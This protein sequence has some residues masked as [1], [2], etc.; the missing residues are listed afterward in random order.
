MK[1]I[2]T[3]HWALLGVIVLRSATAMA[4]PAPPWIP[5]PA[6]S[7]W[8][9]FGGEN[10]VMAARG[11]EFL[12]SGEG[13]LEPASID[14]T[15]CARS[16]HPQASGQPG[17]FYLRAGR[18]DEMGQWLGPDHEVLLTLR[19]YAQPHAT[20]Y[21]VY[22]SADYTFV[23]RG[24]EP[25]AWNLACK[26]DLTARKEFQSLQVRLPLMRFTRR[27]NGGDIRIEGRGF[28]LAGAAL[29]RVPKAAEAA[30]EPLRVAE[31]SRLKLQMDRTGLRRLTEKPRG[32]VYCDATAKHFPL[33]ELRMKKEG[34]APV[35][36]VMP[37]EKDFQDFRAETV[38]ADTVRMRMRWELPNHVGIEAEAMLLPSGQIEW[39]VAIDN[40][41]ALEVAEI[42]FPVLPGFAVG[43]KASDC[44]VFVPT[45]WGRATD[46][47]KP[48]GPFNG[49]RW[50]GHWNAQGGFYL[51]IEDPAFHD[52]VF[53][54]E[55]DTGGRWNLGIRQ[56]GRVEPGRQWRSEVIRAAVTS[57]DWHE[58]GDIYRAFTAKTLAPC[59]YP[60]HVKWLL[61]AWDTSNAND[62]PQQ[63][64]ALLTDGMEKREPFGVYFFATNRQMIEG[65]TSYS[66]VGFPAYP[67]PAWGSEREFRQQLRALKDRGGM[68]VPYLNYQN[69]W[70]FYQEQVRGRQRV[71]YYPKSRLPSDYLKYDD[72]WIDEAASHAY[73]GRPTG[74]MAAGSPAWAD[75]VAQVCRR[76][77]D[78]GMDGMY[79]DQTCILTPSGRT[80]PPKYPGYG[81]NL[82]AR[83]DL[84][85]RIRDEVRRQNPYFTLSGELIIDVMC[86]ALDLPMTSSVFPNLD[87]Y[88]YCN[89][90]HIMIHGGWNGGYQFM[91]GAEQVRSTWQ[92]GVRFEQMVPRTF[93]GAGMY[94]GV[95]PKL[96]GREWDD[97]DRQVLELRRAVKSI[98]Y[99]AEYRDG[100]GL[101]VHDAA[102]KSLE[103]ERSIPFGG[104]PPQRGIFGRW[105]RF[106]KDGES[107]AAINI[108]N[109]VSPPEMALK[110]ATQDSVK[111][112][113]LP[114]PPQEGATM[115]FSTSQT[116][117]V[118][119][120]VAWTLEGKCFAIN[121]RQEGSRY[122]FPVPA[123]EMSSVVLSCGKL[124]PVVAWNLD[125]V[126]A[127]GTCRMLKLKITNVN[128]E[129][130]TGRTR[131]L[132]PKGWPA[133]E[134][135]AFGPLK[136]G[137]TADVE[138]PVVVP[139]GAENGRCDLRC[140]VETA[141][142]T[143]T[144]YN[145]FVVSD[146]VL[147]EFKGCG[148]RLQLWFRNLTDQVQQVEV[149]KLA[150]PNAISVKPLGGTCTLTPR[151]SATMEF[152]LR[153]RV[154][155]REIADA[156]AE[157]VAG[158]RGRALV[159]GVMPIVP[160]GDFEADGAGDRMPDWWIVLEQ[161]KPGLRSQRIHSVNLDKLRL[162]PKNPHAGRYALRLD[163]LDEKDTSL[164]HYQAVPVNGIFAADTRYRVSVWIRSEAES[165]VCLE[166]FGQRLG[167]GKTRKPW[168][169]FSAEVVSRADA[170]ARDY[171]RLINASTKAAWFDD[172]V[173]EELGPV[174]AAK[175]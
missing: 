107:G 12:N 68:V 123:S 125:H 80:Y 124:R 134:P 24:S 106:A 55:P 5:D 161:P 104:L 88:R 52:A 159:H 151:S 37:G 77:N 54:R 131:L 78:W 73:D 49:M 14:G 118:R 83:T 109:A 146:P 152:A 47:T 74:G 156:E 33:V 39:R 175:R 171:C 115:S 43:K 139:A 127:A 128:S 65:P 89:P 53:L 93:F 35:D 116:G 64:F 122:T 117:P 96:G 46:A 103:P 62:Y 70:R 86:Q 155:L 19:Y 81:E 36:L 174:P 126:A 29:S 72:G 1:T 129:P 75:A 61:D 108:V 32:I 4:Q 58:M 76:Y 44:S 157:V 13:R 91:G 79:L 56:W 30:Q 71:L 3:L 119:G 45:D 98:L 48:A 6:N 15:P 164:Q 141:Q 42:A 147:A 120:A 25:G 57:G 111:D 63:G 16:V 38:G 94:A 10:G 9:L 99:D 18:P 82:R 137:Q 21:V 85:R 27:C 170:Y 8:I 84:L 150:L 41:S 154:G 121:G 34:N 40:R 145:F 167:N 130:M 143:F 95:D 144:T 101:S 87:Y 162:D 136:T 90:T 168:Q 158:G 173:V 67:C 102:G 92:M 69:Y 26:E 135:R 140:A 17:Y 160:N 163:G 132:P 31:N 149:K 100:V 110:L 11:I 105:F 59:D 2:G 138:V 133:P 165:G 20:L 166:C 23:K 7:Q 60:D 112:P 66:D 114:L 50:M 113:S 172:L 22:D 153:G 169:Q 148:N 142:G 97:W 28:A 51:G